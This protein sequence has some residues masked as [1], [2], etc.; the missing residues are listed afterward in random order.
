MH[1]YCPSYIDLCLKST[2]FSYK[3]NFHEPQEGATMGS[4]V[5]VTLA[6]LCMDFLED[7][8]LESSTVKMLFSNQYIDDTYGIT[9]KGRR[10]QLL[11]YL[12]GV[13]PTLQFT[14]K[15]EKEGTRTFL[16][17]LQYHCVQE[18]N[19]YCTQQ[20]LN[21]Y[22]LHPLHMNKQCIKSVYDRARCITTTQDNIRRE[23]LCMT[24]ASMLSG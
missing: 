11:A 24:E 7:L 15:L 22:S 1:F 3:G 14:I 10:Q 21:F 13:R 17:T 2:C 12:Y 23:E 6:N 8:A 19:T 18:V 9:R 20:F 5:S 16:D 4:R